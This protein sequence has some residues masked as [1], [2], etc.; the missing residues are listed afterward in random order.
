MASSASFARCTVLLLLVL[1]LLS[2]I[3]AASDSLPP[4]DQ[5]QNHEIMQAANRMLQLSFGN[6]NANANAN[7]HSEED[8]TLLLETMF[9]HD[10]EALANIPQW[11]QQAKLTTASYD[12]TSSSTAAVD[13]NRH[14]K[15]I[16]DMIRNSSSSSEDDDCLHREFDVSD[17]HKFD[18]DEATNDD[19]KQYWHIDGHYVHNEDNDFGNDVA[20]HDRPPFAVN[21]FTP[22]L[23]LKP[24][25]GPTEFCVGTSHL[26]GLD[27]DHYFEKT[28]DND[29]NNTDTIRIL[30]QLQEFEWH[31][32]NGNNNR[33]RPPPE[34]PPPFSR[35]PLLQK[36]DVVL[37]DYMVTHR[38]GS[39]VS[40]EL[41]SLLFAMYSRKWY[42]DTT[43]DG[44]DDDDCDY[45]DD[46]PQECELEFLTKMTRFAVVDERANIRNDLGA[47]DGNDEL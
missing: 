35:Q 34:C 45:Y 19:R 29:D 24:H 44:G 22:L 39:N 37:F 31:V 28:V 7:S 9:A 17:V 26:R 33:G 16:L 27:L 5:R 23:N 15:G 21:L 14:W 47:K 43:F 3:G 18:I 46:N 42:R 11:I 36:G 38:G 8:W 30:Q 13:V 40:D 10:K 6:N 1:L 25:H 2:T 20:G 32:Q 12:S 41:R 4:E